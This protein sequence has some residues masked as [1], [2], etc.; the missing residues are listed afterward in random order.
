MEGRVWPWALLGT[1]LVPLSQLP[2]VMSQGQVG[3][4]G[5]LLRLGPWG[6]W[7][8]VFPSP[9]VHQANCVQRGGRGR[10]TGEGMRMDFKQEQTQAQTQIC[11]EKGQFNAAPARASSWGVSGLSISHCPPFPTCCWLPSG[12]PSPP[13][14]G[15]W[16]QQDPRWLL[17]E[18]SPV[19]GLI[20]WEGKPLPAADSGW[21]KGWWVT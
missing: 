1:G 10:A 5:R 4:Q 3:G 19:W 15:G 2:S 11:R 21:R 9:L 20:E 14:A 17:G 18:L 6:L 12:L 16:L 7:V 13:S 8:P